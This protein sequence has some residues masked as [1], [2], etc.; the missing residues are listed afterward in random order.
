MIEAGPRILPSFP[1][2]LAQSAVEQLGEL[3]VEIMTDARVVALSEHGVE[4]EWVSADDVPGLGR[5]IHEQTPEGRG[6]GRERKLRCSG[7]AGVRANELAKCLGVPLDKQGRVLVKARLLAR[8]GHPDVFAIGDMAHFEQ[9][10][11]ILPGVSPV[12]MQ[13]GRYVARI[14]RAEEEA[15]SVRRDRRSPTSTKGS[16]ATIGRSRAIAWARGL[17]LQASSR[18]SPGSSS[19]S[20]T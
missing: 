18:G 1:E 12:A 14:I 13:Q 11:H 6:A 10:G 4:L 5:V 7:A 19:T 15:G 2:D 9:E 16:M 20:F 3:G 8:P 17:K